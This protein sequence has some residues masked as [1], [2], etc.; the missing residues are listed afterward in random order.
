MY[1]AL[2]LLRI[3]WQFSSNKSLGIPTIKED[4]IFYSFKF[5]PYIVQNQ[6]NYALKLKIMELDR[7]ILK[8]A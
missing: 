3:K 5:V 6:L 7:M 1:I 8:G 4:F 2:C